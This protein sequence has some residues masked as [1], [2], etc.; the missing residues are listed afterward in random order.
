MKKLRNFIFTA[1]CFGLLSTGCG[2]EE[3]G[4]GNGNQTDNRDNVVGVYPVKVTVPEVGD[5]YTGLSLDKE[6]DA[7]LR[8]SATVDI[9]DMDAL[10]IDLV[11][12]ELKE[13]DDEDGAAVTG[14]LFR[15][16]KQNLDIMGVPMT[17][18]GTGAYDEGY[19][20]KVY[21]NG[22][23]AFIS[24][25]IGDAM[26]IVNVVVET[27]TYVKPDDNRGE[28]VGDYPVKVTVPIVGDL[29]TKLSLTEEG[30]AD[31]GISATVQ[32]PQMGPMTIDLVL[33]ELMEYDNDDGTVVTGYLFRIAGQELDIPGVGE[34]TMTGTGV[35]ADGYDGKVYKNDT[36]AFISFE[37]GDASGVVIK[38]ETG[39][40]SPTGG[41]EQLQGIYPAVITSGALGNIPLYTDLQIALNQNGN[42]VVATTVEGTMIMQFELSRLTEYDTENGEPVLGYRFTIA[43][44]DLSIMSMLMVFQ[45]TGKYDGRDGKIYRSETDSFIAFEI[46]DE[47]GVVKVKV[48]SV[49][50]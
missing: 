42:L 11:L 49:N 41:I 50:N 16:E 6:G 22:T 48:E 14:Y 29:Y 20:G 19:D 8:A 31:L 1:L 21:K 2:T 39:T 24:L 37:M 12:S 44:Q 30:D 43:P 34:V 5:I 17:L 40:G 15:I 26:G 23:D 25:E 7:D 3:G 32:V 45:G 27:G 28:V 10:T 13:Y 46:V 47:T 38:V 35:Y 9:P 18:G 36:D 4:G 33:S